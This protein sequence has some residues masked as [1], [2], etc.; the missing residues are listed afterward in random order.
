VKLL[1]FLAARFAWTPHAASAAADPGVPAAPGAMEDCVVLF[2]HVERADAEPAR[3]ASVV[4][5]T[6]KH[7]RWQ[8]RKRGVTRCV[9]H[10]FTHLGAESAEPAFTRALFAELAARLAERGFQV[11]ETPFGYTNAWE[12]AVHGEALAKVWKAVPSA[13]VP[14]PDL[15][16]G[17]GGG[18]A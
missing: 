8:A 18:G 7:V 16:H 17:A 4:R 9:L 12:L 11:T 15:P 6:V 3:R 5:Q 10:S 2:L 1:S 13:D 14:D